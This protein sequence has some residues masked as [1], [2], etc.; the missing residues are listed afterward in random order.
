M[1]QVVAIEEVDGYAEDD[2][3]G[4]GA[5]AGGAP[6]LAPSAPA[7][8]AGSVVGGGGV[9][10]SLARSFMRRALCDDCCFCPKHAK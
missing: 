9:D 4:D 6:G 3:D 8:V 5:G 7:A 2:A 10:E 1:S